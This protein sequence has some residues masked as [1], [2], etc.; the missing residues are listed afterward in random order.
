MERFYAHKRSTFNFWNE[1]AEQYPN[2]DQAA[3]VQYALEWLGV[4]EDQIQG[5]TPRDAKYI[6]DD[7]YQ[8]WIM[9]RSGI[10]L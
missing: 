10:Y 9:A 3:L 5:V 4:Y 8:L 2:C 7:W 6:L 1:Q